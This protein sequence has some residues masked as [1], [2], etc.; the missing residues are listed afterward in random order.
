MFKVINDSEIWNILREKNSWFAGKNAAESIT[1]IHFHP[2]DMN[3]SLYAKSTDLDE[4]AP[5]G[6][7]WSGPVLFATEILE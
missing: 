1:I 5:Y 3:S 2:G 7:V 6:S 4:T